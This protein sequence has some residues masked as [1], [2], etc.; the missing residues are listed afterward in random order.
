M[1]ATS[2]ITQTPATAM[3]E[4]RAAYIADLKLRALSK[5]GQHGYAT[6]LAL[7][8]ALVHTK[9]TASTATAATVGYTKG[10]AQG[11][12]TGIRGG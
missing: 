4:A 10:F 3:I 12:M 11:F 8:G 1:N 9:D 6:G 7:H 5:G 2:V